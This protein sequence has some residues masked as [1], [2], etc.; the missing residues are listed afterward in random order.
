MKKKLTF[1]VSIG[2]DQAPSQSNRR[3]KV[4]ERM[5][6]LVRRLGALLGE[7]LADVPN[8]TTCKS[9]PL[10]RTGRNSTNE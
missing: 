1:T 4:D 3:S 6:E 2:A 5:R 8:A 7:A 10:K 9:K